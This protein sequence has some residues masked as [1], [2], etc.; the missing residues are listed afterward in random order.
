MCFG[1]HEQDVRIFS[2]EYKIQCRNKVQQKIH[3]IQYHIS[4]EGFLL[5]TRKLMN[6]FHHID[7]FMDPY[8]AGG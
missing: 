2:I 4:V 7:Y 5:K 8:C 3:A 6:I 1:N